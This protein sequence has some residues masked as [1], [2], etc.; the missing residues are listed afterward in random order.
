MS[1]H[2]KDAT[3]A[4]STSDWEKIGTP[5]LTV[6]VDSRYTGRWHRQNL[7]QKKQVCS[8]ASD[9]WHW[10][11]QMKNTSDK[12]PEYIGILLLTKML[13]LRLVRGYPATDITTQCTYCRTPTNKCNT[14]T[15]TCQLTWELDDDSWHT[16][17]YFGHNLSAFDD[18]PTHHNLSLSH[19]T[20][21]ILSAP[22]LTSVVSC[23]YL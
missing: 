7:S 9:I 10:G 14:V 4:T 6:G 12:N 3:R 2:L 16:R 11:N 1:W 21:G 19:V 13:R 18:A 23:T 22:T 5:P 20:S 17:V 8:Q 15:I